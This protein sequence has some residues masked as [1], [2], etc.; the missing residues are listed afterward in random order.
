[1]AITTPQTNPTDGL[2]R[3]M[4]GLADPSR[5][6]L[7]RLLERHELGV[8]DLCETVQMPQSTVSRH[9]KI[10]AGEGWLSNRR[11]GTTNLYQMLLDELEPAQR[12]LWLLARDRTED[13]ATHRQ[14]QV[15]LMRLLT[16]R[17]QDAQDFFAG[18]A[19]QWDKTRAESYGEGFEAAALLGLIP[20]TWTVAD[21][22]CGTGSLSARLAGQVA[23]VIAVD[24]S[25]PMLDAARQRTA[26]LDN[27]ELREG[28]LEALPLD[29]ASVDA[30]V[31]VLVL[32]YLP[33]PA[34]ALQEAVRVLKPGGL[35][36][37]V[38][39]MRHDREAFRRDMGQQSM[40]FEEGELTALLADAGLIH[41][42]CQPLPPDPQAKGPALLLA[43]G[44]KPN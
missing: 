6:R 38:D 18:A 30:A 37:L 29:N 33:D 7:L 21:L 42:T 2:I 4:S 41:T 20:P 10:L 39:L 9:L 27:V 40:G 36:V 28:D 12:D 43:R 25:P 11:Q 35:L 16:Q 19:G 8:S 1:M 34:A 17:R 23:S 44:V 15:R 3:W 14:D 5:L 13:W 24:N 31:S 32:T 22:G 26:G